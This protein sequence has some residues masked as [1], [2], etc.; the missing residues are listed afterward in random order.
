MIVTKLWFK[1][2]SAIR[3]TS[4]NHAVKNANFNR[5]PSLIC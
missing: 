2:T 4:Q 5:F 3:L 1:N